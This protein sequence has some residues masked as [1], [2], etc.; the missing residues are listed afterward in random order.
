LNTVPRR[1]EKRGTGDRGGTVAFAGATF[2]RDTYLYAD[3]DGILVAER[4][5][6]A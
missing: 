4:N 1:S 5:L 3:D 6:L 2:K